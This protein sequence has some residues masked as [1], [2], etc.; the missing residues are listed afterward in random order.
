MDGLSGESGVFAV[1]SVGIQLVESINK[2]L[3]SI[4]SLT[5]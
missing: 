4:L 3:D 1:V 2:L 5:M